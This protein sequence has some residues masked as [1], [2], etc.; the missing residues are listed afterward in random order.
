MIK[1]NNERTEFRGN[2][3]MLMAEFTTIVHAMRFD[4]VPQMEL[5]EEPEET[6]MRMVKDG[7]QTEEEPDAKVDKESKDL[8]KNILSK[9]LEKLEGD[10]E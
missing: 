6:I 8:L 10:D 9:V 4:V 5:D 7:L 3:P 2:A 1:I